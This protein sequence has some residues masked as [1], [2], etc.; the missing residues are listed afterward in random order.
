M[1]AAV[2]IKRTLACMAFLVLG[3]TVVAQD[4]DGPSSVQPVYPSADTAG[5]QQW[6]RKASG[7]LILQEYDSAGMSATRAVE[8]S[9]QSFYRPGKAASLFILGQCAL[10]QNQYIV[11]IR[12]YFGALNEFEMLSDTGGMALTNF[13]I[14]KIYS[15][16][17]LHAKAIEYFKA[18]ERLSAAGTPVLNH[19]ELLE[20]KANSYF[21]LEQYENAAGVYHDLM[22]NRNDQQGDGRLTFMNNR[23]TLCYLNLG[24]YEEAL[25][26]NQKL[27]D[28]VRA[29]G[30]RGREMLALNNEGYI[31]QKTGRYEEALSSFDESLGLQHALYPDQPENPVI[32]LNK[33]ILHQNL[34]DHPSAVQTLQDAIRITEQTG[35]DAKRAMLLHI[36]ANVFFLDQDVYNAGV[37]NDKARDLALEIQDQSLLSEIYLL[38]SKIDEALY[39]FEHSFES[40]RKHLDL[41][42]SLVS[43]EERKQAELIQQRY[44]VERAEKEI[45]QL[46]SSQEISDMELIQLRLE[47]RSR[48]QQ[49]EIYRKNDSL[50][51]TVI[52]NQQLERDRA[53]QELLL[54][55]E[56]LAAERKDREIVDLKQR[57]EIQTLELRKKELEQKQDQQEIALLTRDKELGELALSKARARNFFMLGISL[58]VLAILYAVYQGLR[59]ARKANRKLARQNLEINQQK[60]EINRNLTIIDEERKKSDAL[61]LNILPAETAN[62]LKEKGQ[63]IPKHYEMVTILFT[64]FVGFTFVAERMSPQELIAELNHCFLEFD[65]IIDRHGVE[66]IKTIGDSYMCAGGIPVPNTSNPVDVVLAALEIRDF[67]TRTRQER[68]EAGRDYWEVRIGVNTGPVMAGVVGKNKFAYDIWGDAVNT[69]SR[70]ESSGKSG[71]V[72][73]S[74]NTFELVRDRFQCTYRGKVQA[75]NKGEVDMYFVER[76][77]EKGE[78]REEK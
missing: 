39:D 19:M 72:N 55:E 37:Y 75:K 61:L 10:A 71:Q 70:M 15:T 13:Q 8:L 12:H 40:Y 69:A 38:T 2:S 68:I 57:E 43:A 46:L 33:A 41:K 11:S 45:S 31:L 34:G 56:R 67:V 48:Q 4:T 63:S 30:D 58:L 51:K 74:G 59:F 16:A 53:L 36:L 73:I 7:H 17:E 65:R 78:R 26:A 27:L 9:R 3:A 66:K 21:L 54:A 47:S 18:A 76:R 52:Q 25:A 20:A 62:E 24:R 35:D 50:Q 29:G 23:L 14:G 22:A 42:D 6:I 64:D 60:E 32:L 77:E 44:I 49:L 28:L 5:I 1:T